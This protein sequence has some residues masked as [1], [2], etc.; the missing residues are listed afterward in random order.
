MMWIIV[1]TWSFTHLFFHVSHMYY[2][3]ILHLPRPV[4]FSTL[5]FYQLQLKVEIVWVL[6]VS[7][8]VY[9]NQN[10]YLGKNYK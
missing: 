10:F 8:F 6:A 9:D 7:E 5:D 2:Y 3:F 1:T 4:T